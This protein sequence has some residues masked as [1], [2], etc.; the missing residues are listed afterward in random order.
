LRENRKKK[1]DRA[2]KQAERFISMVAHEL[3]GPLGAATNAIQLLRDQETRAAAKE[4]ALLIANRQLA[5]MSS[6]VGDLLDW[7]RITRDQLSFHATSVD[8]RACA[9][10]A[11]AA[12]Q[13]LAYGK[14]Q[15]LVLEAPA[16]V[17]VTADRNRVVQILFSLLDNA[18]KYS[19]DEATVELRIRDGDPVVVEV[20]DS[21]TGFPPGLLP[22][23]FEFDKSSASHESGSDGLGL[24]LPI[25]K[26][27]VEM[28]GGSISA[29][30]CP[31]LGGACVTVHLPSMDRAAA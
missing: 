28:H 9:E 12:V 23:V 3:R 6:L 10:E 17:A 14:G 26:K 2:V 30:R 27:L 8:L 31:R 18:C 19:P 22:R 21:G 20:A 16:C 24:G 1:K 5:M 13:S 25:T 7:G 11:M 4:G 15:R 29:A